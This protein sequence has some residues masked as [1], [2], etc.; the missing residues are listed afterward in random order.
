MRFPAEV[1]GIW[2]LRPQ[3]SQVFLIE[4]IS[5]PTPSWDCA[6]IADLVAFFSASDSS[7]KQYRLPKYFMGQGYQTPDQMP[8]SLVISQSAILCIVILRRGHPYLP[9]FF[10]EFILSLS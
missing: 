10:A 4:Q 1:P 6:R 5:A 9:R 7:T 3:E 2:L 8:K